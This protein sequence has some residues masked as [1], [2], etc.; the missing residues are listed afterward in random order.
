MDYTDYNIIKIIPGLYIGDVNAINFE[1]KL[2]E[3][4]INYLININNTLEGRNFTTYNISINSNSE[5]IDSSS[6]I[7][8][9]LNI[10]AEF[11][12]NALQNNSNILICD[13]NYL[14]P[15]LIIG[16]FL[17]KY[18]NISY[19]E[20]VYWLAKKLNMNTISKN[21]CYQLFL[22]YKSIN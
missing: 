15:F 6:L 22:Y 16:G 5:Y 10:T 11:I 7:K 13:I 17:I 18:L 21:I 8:I 20:C 1:N 19:T 12:I 14:V 9:N 3:L 2:E 4:N